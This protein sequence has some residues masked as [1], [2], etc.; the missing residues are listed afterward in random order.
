MT[1]NGFHY[2]LEGTKY[3]TRWGSAKIQ[4]ITEGLKFYRC[5]VWTFRNNGILDVTEELSKRTL[6]KLSKP[7]VKK[8]AKERAEVSNREPK[9]GAL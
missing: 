1:Q 2:P 8:T 4:R 6:A 9:I 7:L 5:R 3:S